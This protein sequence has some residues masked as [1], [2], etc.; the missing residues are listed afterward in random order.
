MA[1]ES[2][3]PTRRPPRIRMSRWLYYPS[4][5][6]T[7]AAGVWFIR[8]D[9]PV[10]AG[11]TVFVSLCAATGFSLGA[12]GLLQTLAALA[13]AVW[14]APL[15]APFIEDRFATWFGT[16]G[17]T[18]RF[19]CVALLAVTISLVVTVVGSL[20]SRV[21][22][23]RRRKRQYFDRHLGL[24]LGAAEGGVVVLLLLGG[25]VTF[26][27]VLE[28]RGDAG[29]D[30]R[31]QNRYAA[32]IGTVAEETRGSVLGPIVRRYNPLRRVPMLRDVPRIPDTVATL[33]EPRNLD[34]LLE[35][36]DIVA[37]RSDPEF[38]SAI[39]RLRDDPQ[40]QQ[41]LQ[42]PGRLDREGVMTLMNHPV[43]LEI[44]DHGDF[45]GRAWSAV[46]DIR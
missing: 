11:A 36:P 8:Q 28:R 46:E 3:T 12:T 40:I 45:A 24:A 37:L 22:V 25:V 29:V 13:L 4:L 35:H 30:G 38:Q 26:D 39:D 21:L 5:L 27:A 44:V 15:G 20:L 1:S 18:N 23:S 2:E 9:D 34:R 17:L 41:L 14:L 43:V 33:S 42:Q 6:A 31:P 32:A 7:V 10:A 16:S 19:L